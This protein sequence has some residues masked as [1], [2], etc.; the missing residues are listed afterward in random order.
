MWKTLEQ[1]SGVL[2]YL[3][4][5]FPFVCL[6]LFYYRNRCTICGK[7]LIYKGYDETGKWACPEG[8]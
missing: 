6:F 5:L 7:K 3:L 8:H 4:I 2:T 1:F